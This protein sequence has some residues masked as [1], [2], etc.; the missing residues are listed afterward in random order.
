MARLHDDNLVITEVGG[1]PLPPAEGRL[2]AR[3]L[4]PKPSIYD[5]TQGEAIAGCFAQA[6]FERLVEGAGAI[7]VEADDGGIGVEV[8]VDAGQEVAFAMDPPEGVGVREVESGE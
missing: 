3:H 1:H 5:L 2:G 8:D 7:A 6:G 4:N